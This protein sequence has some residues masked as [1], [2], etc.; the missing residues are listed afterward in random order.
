MISQHSRST[1]ISLRQTPRQVHLLVA[2]VPCEQNVPPVEKRQ[3]APRTLLLVG[4]GTKFLSATSS[5]P[6]WRYFAVALL[7]R[8]ID[9][10]GHF[11][12]AGPCEPPRL[13]LGKREAVRARVEV[14]VRIPALD[15]LAH[16]DRALV[17]EGFAVVEEVDPPSV[18]PASSITRRNSSKSSIP[19]CRVRVMPVSGAQHA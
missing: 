1:P 19:A 7:A 13:L 16:L 17:Q 5:R 14:D 15:V 18:G 3:V 12:D 6:R 11:V 2:V 9:R 4:H 8:P 10:E